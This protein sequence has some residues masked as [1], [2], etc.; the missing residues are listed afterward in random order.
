MS[1]R[2]LRLFFALWPDAD[3][4]A[5]TIAL[6]RVV[7]EQSGGKATPPERMHL[8]LAF[9]GAQSPHL[10]TALR[11]CV[12]DF[13]VQPFAIEFDRIGV[14]RTTA[15]AWLAASRPPQ[16]LVDL[17]R[18][19]IDALRPALRIDEERAFSP[20]VTLARRVQRK[21]LTS[22]L[23]AAVVWRIGAF[24]LV[25]SQQGGDGPSYRRIE[26]WQLAPRDAA[27]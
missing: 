14:W 25:S 5:Q 6:S 12:S 16:G 26:D 1:E 22:R 13:A 11:A 27:H 9:L 20:H 10:V 8:T 3:G 23:E 17:N 18:S 4:A 19:L 21:P 2:R 24:S 7:A 15:I